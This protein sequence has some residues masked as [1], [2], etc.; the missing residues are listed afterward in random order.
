[1]ARAG[2]VLGGSG[3]FLGGARTHAC[4]AFAAADLALKTRVRR[5]G[6]AR[7][8]PIRSRRCAEE[9][10][11]VRQHSWTAAQRRVAVAVTARA[12]ARLVVRR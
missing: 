12:A 1:M 3:N 7:L 8:P 4:Q 6:Q 5:R 11:D 2:G 10:I 9:Q